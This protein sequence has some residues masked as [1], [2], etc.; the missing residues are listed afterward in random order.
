MLVVDPLGISGIVSA[1]WTPLATCDTWRGAQSTAA[2]ITA[3]DEHAARGETSEHKFWLDHAEKALA[4]MLYA[5]GA[6]RLRMR[7]LVA[8][9]D[10]RDDSLDEVAK[11]LDEL[12]TD[13]AVRAWQAVCAHVPKT[14]DGLWAQLESLLKVYGDDRVAEF[15]DGHDLNPAQFLAGDNTLYLYA[16]PHEQARLRPLFELVCAGLIQ[17]AQELAVTYPSGQLELPLLLALDEA[18]NV[19]ALAD[20]PQVV[21]TGRGQGIQVLSVWHDWAQLKHRYGDRAATVL[22]GHRAKLLLPG[23]ADAELLKLGADLI[24]DRAFTETTAAR[25]PD[26]RRSTSQSTTSYR[27]LLPVDELG[28]LR[29]G[30]AIAL[31]GN[32]RPARLRLRPHYTLLE[33]HRR[34]AQQRRERCRNA[35]RLRWQDALAATRARQIGLLRRAPAPFPP[36]TA[37]TPRSSSTEG[38]DRAS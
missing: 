38:A 26:G 9:A 14:F 35:R 2:M 22:N 17:A 36:P 10:S 13:A 30:T 19:A 27:P 24:G 3:T 8:W 11:L 33:R 28:R 4:P 16:P 12:G 20:L 1:R 31:Y 34:V 25:D 18:A 37:P 6:S 32:R 29:T 21:T 5:A 7:D 23:I 15:T